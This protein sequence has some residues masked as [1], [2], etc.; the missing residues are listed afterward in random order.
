MKYRS[1]VVAI[2]LFT[3]SI[4]L[5]AQARGLNAVITDSAGQPISGATVILRNKKTKAE[6]TASTNVEGRVSFEGIDDVGSYEIAIA[7]SGFAK[8]VQDVKGTDPSFS[9][10]L[11][12]QALQE[13]VTVTAARTEILTTETAV[14]VS[15]VD[16]EEIDRRGINTIGDIFRTLPG[17]STINE[18]AFQVRPRIR[19]L[20][21]NR[22]L[23]LV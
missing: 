2:L 14:P 5:L 16:R 3:F 13:Q 8:L 15:V 1:I 21:S 7:A 11:E 9:I 20:D 17:T 10:S 18:G 6:R 23:I 12:P 4:S 19:G 22:V